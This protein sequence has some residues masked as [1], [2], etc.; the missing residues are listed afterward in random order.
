MLLALKELEPIEAFLDK[1]VETNRIEKY[2][3]YL[4]LNTQ[5]SVDIVGKEDESLKNE[6]E[7]NPKIHVS[8]E[9]WI[10]PSE[11]ANDVYYQKLFENK[12]DREHRRRLTNLINHQYVVSKNSTPV[13]TFYSYK[14][15]VGRTTSLVTF[16]NYYAYQEKKKVVILDFDFEAPGFTNYFDFSL[17]T[18]TEKNGVVEYLLDREAS[19][20]KLNLLQDYIIEVSNEYSGDGSIYVMPSGNLYGEKN[21]ES[22]LEALSRIDINNPEVIINQV[23]S[24]ILH[25]NSELQPDVILIDSRTGFNDVFGFLLHSISNVVVGL[26]EDN[27]QTEPGLKLFLKDIYTNNPNQTSAILVNSL[28]H[29]STNY[30]KRVKS[31][32]DKVNQYII[33]LTDEN[34]AP[35]IFDLRNSNI[36]GN[37]GTIEDDKDDYFDFIKNSTPADYEK[38]FEEIIQR[39]AENKI[40]NINCE[41]N[42]LNEGIKTIPCI[43]SKSKNEDEDEDEDESIELL[44]H[45]LLDKIYKNFPQSYAENIIYDDKYLNETFYFRKCM[46]DIFN[47]DKFLLIGGKGTGKT[48]FYSALR[49]N[50]F[51]ENLKI[52]ANKKQLKFNIIDIISLKE[53]QEKNKY[54]ET[55]TFD[56]NNIK[57]K[58]FFYRRFWITYI[59][60]SILLSSKKIGY[61][62][63][64]EIHSLFPIVLNNT[65]KNKTFLEEVI[66][67]DDKFILIE[68]ELEKID[69]HLKKNDINLLII[70][71][72]LDYIVKPN[73]WAQMVAPLIDYCRSMPYIK[74]QPKL[75]LR[76]DLFD[77]LTNITNKNSLSAKIIDLEWS[78]DEIFAFFFK[79]VFAYTKDEFFKIME[80]YKEFSLDRIETIKKQINKLNSYNQIDLD[81][82]KI[83]SLVQTFF[84]K[85][86]NPN[87]HDRNTNYSKSYDWFFI[88]LADSNQTFSLRL[89]LDLIKFAI[90]RTFVNENTHYPKPI[91]HP[92]FYNHK[93]PRKACVKNYFEDLSNEEGN[94]DFK[95]I[96]EN[97]RDSSKF[98]SKLRLRVLKGN[99]YDAFLNYFLTEESVKLNNRTK[100]DIEEILKI[101][102]AIRIYYITNNTKVC[103]FAYLYKFY[104]N[105][106]G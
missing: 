51:L 101:N 58:E 23:S 106:K 20:E 97:I 56:Q 15:G 31:F 82:Y 85:Y 37:L 64:K 96:I 75:F 13:I 42:I 90:E 92:F 44:K 54:F 10:A 11:Y 93:D 34:I 32:T 84:G 55:K 28:V 86:A 41:S 81:I 16:A 69:L 3:L 25:I 52:K 39:I 43:Q 36:L 35:S 95:N 57:D 99:E 2:R 49:N 29:K 27:I 61:V 87:P 45:N 83:E 70:F 22:Y 62:T 8:I 102:G 88:S 71:D 79:I 50:D 17:A 6:I 68:N 72:Q 47:F 26:F 80:T 98:P 38:L 14:G 24:L 78:K 30:I 63:S 53:S 66:Q 73:L 89:F 105:L 48:T 76:R 60:N 1:L 59:L 103:E 46:E 9:E 91:L 74:I 67:N 77:R 19:K 5:I 4:N 18:L 104:L 100:N 12:I 94:E 33:E 65:V 40:D 21:L 7:N